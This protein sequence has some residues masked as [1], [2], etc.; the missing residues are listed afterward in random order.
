M[1]CPFFQP[2]QPASRPAHAGAR[3]PL[4]REYDGL[5]HAGG[6]PVPAPAD[7]RFQCCNRG[8]SG[9]DCTAFPD[10]ETLS[11][12][13]YAIRAESA[14]MLQVLCIEE[15]EHRPIRWME[16]G[17]D[18]ASGAVEGDMSAIMRAQAAAFARA[19]LDCRGTK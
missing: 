9:D 17:Y 19:Y 3:L 13:R 7:V 8:Y 6:A 10:S 14:Q 4:I 1:A 15:S 12:L 18:I 5:C 11:C 16:A 2:L